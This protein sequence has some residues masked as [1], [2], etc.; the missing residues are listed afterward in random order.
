M[1]T[2]RLMSVLAIVLLTAACT[3]H[4]PYDWVDDSRE[5]RIVF[6]VDPD[7][8]NVLLNG[9]FIGSAYEFSKPSAALRLYSTDHELVIKKPGFREEFIRLSD[10]STENITIRLK[11][12][13][14]DRYYPS[15]TDRGPRDKPH[16]PAE[17]RV[18][19][20]E[21]VAPDPAKVAPPS[22][23][24]TTA[25][26]AVPPPAAPVSPKKPTEK[27]EESGKEGKNP[28]EPVTVTLEIV[29]SES[30]IYLNGKFWGLS[31]ISG[32]IDNLR[33]EPG[34]YTLQIVKPGFK[35]YKAPLD[36]KDKNLSII[37]RLQELK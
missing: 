37:I 33:L 26:T 34:Q 21:D 31:P 3:F 2:I 17:P 24:T 5:Y 25:K 27:A 4:I 14:D 8:A 20:P 32:A 36:V 13:R 7:D 18:N 35:E 19:S 29:P 12:L 10:Y 15:K 28:T 9:K 23:Q 16:Q 1:K 6:L 22:S 11:L 30:S